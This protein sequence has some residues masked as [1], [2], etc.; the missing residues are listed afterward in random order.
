MK[1]LRQK[2]DPKK[3]CD[4]LRSTFPLTI[5]SQEIHIWMTWPDEI[6]DI[7]LLSS[8]ELILTQEERQRCQRFLREKDRKMALITRAFSR[9]VLSRYLNIQ[10]QEVRFTVDGNQKPQLL[11]P[12]LPLS[13]NLSHTQGL[14]ICS[15]ILHADIGC[16]VELIKR[17]NAFME[18]AKRYFAACEIN[19]LKAMPAD[20]QQKRF[21][22]YWTLK[23]SYL[24][25]LG[26]GLNRP[27]NDCSFHIGQKSADLFYNSN[28][29]LTTLEEGAGEKCRSFLYYPNDTHCIA[30]TVAN[31]EHENYELSVF[32][33]MQEVYNPSSP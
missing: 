23:E 14:I 7:S 29:E 19:D 31:A 4:V 15:V 1:I 28:I 24:K 8:Y 20:I 25:A 32:R 2:E 18:I 5:E 3:N 33:I 16:D 27:L 21:F 17:Q 22:E 30:M 11:E 26:D 12:S 10:P 9:D 13:F 6:T